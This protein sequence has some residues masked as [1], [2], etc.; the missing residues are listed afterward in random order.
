MIRCLCFNVN[1]NRKKNIKDNILD[2]RRPTVTIGL[3]RLFLL[4]LVCYLDARMGRSLYLRTQ[5]AIMARRKAPQGDE[6]IGRIIAANLIR[7]GFSDRVIRTTEVARLVTEKTGKRMSPQRVSGILNADRVT[8]ETI[9]RLAKGLG[10]K[11]EELT[12]KPK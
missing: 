9:E 12:R 7:L 2:L 11:P 8:P 1:T 10:V 6:P 4:S 5:R 3:R